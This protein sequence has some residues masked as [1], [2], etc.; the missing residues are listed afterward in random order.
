[1]KDVNEEILQIFN[2][3]TAI[4]DDS[5]LEGVMGEERVRLL[6]RHV[7]DVF[8]G[9]YTE[10]ESIS[11]PDLYE[12]PMKIQK[13]IEL[14]A[15][16]GFTKINGF[17]RQHHGYVRDTGEKVTDLDLATF[18]SFEYNL[19]GVIDS[20]DFAI[21]NCKSDTDSFLFRGCNLA[22]FQDLGISS[23]EDLQSFVGKSF[24][25]H[26]FLSTTTSLGGEFTMSSPVVLAIHVPLESKFLPM[27]LQ[28]ALKGEKE[29]LLERETML[30]IGG[31][32]KIGDQYFVYM[33]ST[34]L[35]KEIVGDIDS[36]HLTDNDE[37]LHLS[38]SYGDTYDSDLSIMFDDVGDVDDFSDSPSF[39]K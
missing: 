17:L 2:N 21:D 22:Q 6:E 20:L 18:E 24:T 11:Q 10:G 27:D 15:G 33:C 26:A 36:I 9:I 32:E 30:S 23:L 3:L 8:R 16:S 7:M 37:H 25:E 38:N 39:K 1:M 14:Y 34:P 4:R 12:F 13:A 19:D 31:V 5:F 29:V 28:L 35:D